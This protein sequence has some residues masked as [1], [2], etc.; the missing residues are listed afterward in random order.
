MATRDYKNVW[1]I[2][3]FV[4]G[5]IINASLEILQQGKKIA[6]GN[7]EKLVATIIGN[8]V[9]NAVQNVIAYGADDVIVV[10]G[11]DF[12]LYNT[13]CYAYAV[14]KL[15]EKYKPSVLLAGATK[16]GRDLLSRVASILKVGSVADCTGVEMGENG[17]IEWTRPIFGGNLL[18]TV[19]IPYVRPQIGTIRSGTY[20]KGPKDESRTAEILIENIST[21]AVKIRTKVVEILKSVEEGIKLEEADIVVA[22]GRGLGKAENVKLLNELAA[23]LGGAV[24]GTRACVDAGWMTHQQ[25]IGQSGK[26]VSPKLYIGCGI[27]GA[28]QHTGGISSSDVIIAINKDPDA[29][30]FE[31]AD[32]GIV[33]DLFEVV[34]VLI[35]EIKNLKLVSA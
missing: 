14:V 29:P 17:V 15:I 27:S 32:Y 1:V 35:E 6:S 9:E 5:K 30:I 23:V 4:D 19:A 31:I 33:G 13:D 10:E 16:N 3:E 34:P 26:K 8:N 25:Q 28:I 7:G 21:A 11:Q 2:T 24:G 18:T 22:G 20:K 12:E